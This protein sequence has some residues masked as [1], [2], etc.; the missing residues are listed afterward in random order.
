MFIRLCMLIEPQINIDWIYKTK[1]TV[2]L[3][4]NVKI[5]FE[6]GSCLLDKGD[7]SDI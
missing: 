5:S 3:F 7:N 1:K 4:F 6:N 2:S